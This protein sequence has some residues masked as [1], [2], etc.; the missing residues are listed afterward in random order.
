MIGKLANLYNAVACPLHLAY[1]S[2]LDTSRTAY[3]RY[4]D[5]CLG[6]AP[7]RIEHRSRQDLQTIFTAANKSVRKAGLFYG[8]AI[9][10]AAAGT[11]LAFAP[12]LFVAGWLGAG[13]ALHKGIKISRR[14]L[15]LA[16][17][18]ANAATAEDYLDKMEQ[19]EKQ[20]PNLPPPCFKQ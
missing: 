5:R 15:N 4:A 16:D 12:A 9:A 7:A 2:A 10:S 13:I 3:I 14:R 6:I 1:V 8:A 19:Q 18:Y 17:W 20:A 11:L